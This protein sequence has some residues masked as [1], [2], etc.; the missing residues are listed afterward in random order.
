MSCS[1]KTPCRS[2]NCNLSH[3]RLLNLHQEGTTTGMMEEVPSDHEWR[4]GLQGANGG[5]VAPST[6]LKKE[7]TASY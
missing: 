5:Y 7:H 2:E 6:S 1:L 3:L 4:G